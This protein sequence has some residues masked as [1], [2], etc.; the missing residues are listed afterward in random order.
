MCCARMGQAER[1][2]ER[3][4]FLKFRQTESVL[5]IILIMCVLFL[6][7]Y[8]VCLSIERK[9]YPIIIW[10]L[11]FVCHIIVEVLSSNIIESVMLLKLAPIIL[12]TNLCTSL[13]SVSHVFNDEI[14]M[15]L[16]LQY[17]YRTQLL[18]PCPRTILFIMPHRT[19]LWN[20][21][22]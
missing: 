14:G 2:R 5:F 15:L 8:F 1:R 4:I 22:L 16:F 19:L 12:F 6:C 7:H 9:R 10:N 21:G 17:Y 20:Q 11:F 3:N 18:I 13:A